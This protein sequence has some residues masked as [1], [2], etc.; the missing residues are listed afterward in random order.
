MHLVASCEGM[1]LWL[2][3]E[4]LIEEKVLLTDEEIKK[5]ELLLIFAKEKFEFALRSITDSVQTLL[6]LGKVENFLAVYWKNLNSTQQLSDV[7]LNANTDKQQMKKYFFE[8][9]AKH[10]EQA[11]NILQK[12]EK[13]MQGRKDK[14]NKARIN[15]ELCQVM[16]QMAS[17][18]CEWSM[19]LQSDLFSI[20][21]QAILYDRK[22]KWERAWDLI[23]EGLVRWPRE[24]KLKFEKEVEYMMSGHLSSYYH[25]RKNCKLFNYIKAGRVGMIISIIIKIEGIRIVNERMQRGKYQITE[26]G[27]VMQNLSLGSDWKILTLFL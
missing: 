5:C 21:S 22:K 13:I 10:Y 20:P 14:S 17:C 23:Q 1:T 15:K 11:L 27:E 9:S 8:L 19:A 2:K 3:S 7:N 26:N 24:L 25:I 6:H 12:R 4:K 18:L 16:T